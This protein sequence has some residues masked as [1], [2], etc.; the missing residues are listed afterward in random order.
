MLPEINDCGNVRMLIGVGSLREDS[1]VAKIKVGVR[2]VNWRVRRES[3]KA[4]SSGL[5]R[6]DAGVHMQ[7]S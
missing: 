3:G 1:D 6:S 2:E 4:S 5:L 7:N